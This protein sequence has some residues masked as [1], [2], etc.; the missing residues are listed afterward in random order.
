MT[1]NSPERHTPSVST[2][3]DAELY[4]ALKARDRSALGVLFSRHGRLVYGLTLKI[5]QNP[6]EAEDLTQEIFLILWRNAA[7]NVECRYFVSYLVTLARS[8]AIDRVRAR[9]R[10][11]EILQNWSQ[12]TMSDPQSH[13]TPLEA[14]MVSENTHHVREALTQLSDN[15][16]QVIELAYHQGMSQTEIAKQLNIP[17]GTVKTYTRQGFL[18][19]RQILAPILSLHHE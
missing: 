7:K 18:K 17:L 6:Q 4:D 5:L 15:Q 1:D 16:R 19:L 9:K 11:A 2:M 13:K 3:N 10:H 8:R 14:A 12:T